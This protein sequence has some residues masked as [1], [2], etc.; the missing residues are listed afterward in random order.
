LYVYSPYPYVPSEV[1]W[2]L[3]PTKA[4]VKPASSRVTWGAGVPGVVGAVVVGA[5][6]VGVVVCGG[7]G[8]FFFFLQYFFLAFF[9]FA[10]LHFFLL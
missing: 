9:V 2:S 8:A 6:V 4:F 3:E 10:F 1:L 5:V 7:F